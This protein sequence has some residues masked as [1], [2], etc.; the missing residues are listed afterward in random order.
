MAETSS[1]RDLPEI[2]DIRDPDVR[3]A[4][5]AIHQDLKDSVD[6]HQLEIEALV[7]IMLEKR[8]MSMSEY[9]LHVSRLQQG[10]SQRGERVHEELSS[11]NRAATSSAEEPERTIEDPARS[12]ETDLGGRYRLDG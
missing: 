3:R 5:R 4:V 9:R 8:V 11:I 1:R 7:Q 12:P 6:R 2:S 10:R